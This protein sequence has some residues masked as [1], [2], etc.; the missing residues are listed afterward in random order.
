MLEIE[1][2]EQGFKGKTLFTN[3]SFTIQEGEWIGLQG[4]NGSGK[5]TLAKT[6]A[7][8]Y[9]PQK[10]AVYYKGKDVH[11]ACRYNRL[12]WGKE[13]HL[14]FQE[15]QAPLN[16]LLTVKETIEEP[17][18]IHQ[19]KGAVDEILDLISLPSRLL[20]QPTRFLSGGEKR[21]VAIGRALALNPSFLICDEALTNLDHG[22]V[23]AFLELFLRLKHEKRMTCLFITHE[24]WQADTLCEHSLVLNRP[25]I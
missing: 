12:K 4:A 2:L 17:W 24:K 11:A 7:G 5:T 9:T 1:N 21:R 16:P 23:L 15:G 8:L 6:I 3:L 10:G 20:H 19:E 14:I 22:S 13:V 18:I 25:G